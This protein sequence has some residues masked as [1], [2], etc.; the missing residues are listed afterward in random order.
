L[1]V[2]CDASTLIA[3]ARIGQL[4]ILGCAGAQ[5]MI[6]RAVYDEV[7]VKGVGKPGAD[8]IRDAPWIETHEV[9]DRNVVARFRVILDA[10]ESEAIALAQ[11]V[12]ADVIILDDEAARNTARAAGLRVV[13]LLAFLILAKE[14]EIISHVRPLL[15]ALNRQ[16][17]FIGDELYHHI[18][19]QADEL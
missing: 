5:V 8:E 11:E 7:V 16:G 1:N 4:D 3:L 2:V 18:L 9:A 19:R 10:G 12:E 13:G 15:D 17:F 14:R 6:P